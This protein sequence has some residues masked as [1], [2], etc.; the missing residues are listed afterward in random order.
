V[1][2]FLFNAEGHADGFLFQNGQQVY[3]APHLSQALL[4]QVKVGD[5]VRVRALKPR[6][7]DVLVALSLVTH[8]GHTLEDLGQAAPDTQALAKHKSVQRDGMVTRCLFGPRGEV[9]GALL[10]DGSILCLQPRGH[11]ALL[12]FLNPG[13]EITVWGSQIC[14]KRQNIIDIERL[15]FV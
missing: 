8:G 9:S 2:R 15:A 13:A 7:A 11:A 10:E 14:F 3:F 5:S 6:G 1:A 12:H 4:K